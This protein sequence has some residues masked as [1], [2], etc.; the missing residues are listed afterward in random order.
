MLIDVN[1]VN[2]VPG[3]NGLD[4]PRI[5]RRPAGRKRVVPKHRSPAVRNDEEPGQEERRRLEVYA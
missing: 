4:R 3:S 2:P 1:L 5:K